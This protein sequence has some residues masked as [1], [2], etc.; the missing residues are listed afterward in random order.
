M[1]KKWKSIYFL[2]FLLIVAALISLW[3][4]FIAQRNFRYSLLEQWNRQLTFASE[5]TTLTLENY[6]AKLS[7]ALQIAARTPQVK[8]ILRNKTSTGDF[9]PLETA[10]NLYRDNV[11]AILLLDTQNTVKKR[12]PCAAGTQSMQH[13]P[14]PKHTPVSHSS[15]PELSLSDV[16]TNKA[17]MQTVSLS[18]PIVSQD[19]P[20]GY[21]KWIITLDKLKNVL[22]DEED[23][24]ENTHINVFD[25]NTMQILIPSSKEYS[26]SEND[27]L[28]QLFQGESAPHFGTRI[29]L[30]SAGRKQSIVAYHRVILY[31]NE[32]VVCI[33]MPYSKL[34]S[35]IF[36]NALF[37]FFIAVLASLLLSLFLFY[38]LRL[39]NQRK[40]AEITAK[41]NADM[42]RASDALHYERRLRLKAAIDS[43]E[44][45]QGRIS[46]E[47]HDGLGQLL[48]AIRLKI[49][50]IKDQSLAHKHVMSE[51]LK[52][53]DRA[54][55]EVK[56]I[57]YHLHPPVFNDLG[58][59]KVLEQL[60][61]LSGSSQACKVEYVS[62]G[63]E[64]IQNPMV[65]NYIYRICQEALA[66]AIRHSGA[67]EVN[68][69]LLCT[70]DHATLIVQDN[71]SGFNIDIDGNIGNGIA[72]M[73][74]RTGLLNGIFEIIST[75]GQGTTITIRLPLQKDY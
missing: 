31:G 74:D 71:G 1:I 10:Y 19:K 6:F 32:W 68:V 42:L 47:L 55:G 52:L 25:L 65:R 11:N 8:D 29:I 9:C 45:E 50:D 73:R 20:I 4:G 39:R 51:I 43:R 23:L 72:N 63:T 18:C 14:E 56:S 58:V 54:V 2:G 28:L 57:S 49:D 22:I 3:I 40:A 70:H 26:S 36:N 46:R 7:G 17:G 30:D 64:F 13:C 34:D 21:L 53:I 48:L 67:Y 35:A 37:T 41:Y 12:F 5:M 66:N 59:D 27:I 69:Q 15:Y 44:A 62:H 61:R 33:V 38:F 16:F 60:C 75:P 24:P